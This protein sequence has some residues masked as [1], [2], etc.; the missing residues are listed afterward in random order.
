M[1][2]NVEQLIAW[3]I[4]GLI[5]AAL[6]ALPVGTGIYVSSNK[7]KFPDEYRSG[8][9]CGAEPPTQKDFTARDIPICLNMRTDVAERTSTYCI[10][11]GGLDK[12]AV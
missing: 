12:P 3:E 10:Q 8:Y 9:I 2:I 1:K 4:F 11:A 7:G 6:I 5:I